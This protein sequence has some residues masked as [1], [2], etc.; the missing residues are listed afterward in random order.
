MDYKPWQE[1]DDEGW[2]LPTSWQEVRERW[3]HDYPLR[4]V[5]GIAVV[6]VLGVVFLFLRIAG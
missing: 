5:I 1:P 2:Q 6:L 4:A 3:P